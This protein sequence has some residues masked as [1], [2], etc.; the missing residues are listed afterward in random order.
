MQVRDGLLT[1]YPAI[2]TRLVSKSIG[3]VSVFLPKRMGRRCG[4]VVILLTI[5]LDC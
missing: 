1:N 5:D 2:G 4:P 3:M